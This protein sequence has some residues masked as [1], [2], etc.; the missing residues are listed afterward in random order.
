MCGPMLAWRSRTH[1]K[2]AHNLS[3]R[4]KRTKFSSKQLY[5]NWTVPI[6]ESKTQPKRTK[7]SI[8]GYSRSRRTAIVL[9]LDLV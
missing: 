6:E 4:E 5:Y 8:P 2:L 7:F 1:T 3:L 9:V